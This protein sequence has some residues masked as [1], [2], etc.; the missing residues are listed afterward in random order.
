[1]HA[2]SSFGVLGLLFVAT[3]TQALT[4]AP[5]PGCFAR[6]YDAA[7]LRAHPSQKVTAISGK[8]TRNSQG[9]TFPFELELTLRLKGER[10]SHWAVA[11]CTPLNN[12][13]LH[14]GIE[15]DGGEVTLSQSNAGLLINNPRS[16]GVTLAG[17]APEEDRVGIVASNP[18]HRAFLLPVALPKACAK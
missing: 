12:S 6:T 17:K 7:H 4:P 13:G 3:S 9:A 8:L 18:E 5:F 10:K 14:C 2:T 15:E 11:G 1:M 16:F